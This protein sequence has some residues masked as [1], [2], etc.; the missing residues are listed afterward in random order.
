MQ[1]REASGYIQAELDSLDRIQVLPCFAFGVYEIFNRPYAQF[2]HG[3]HVDR[4]ALGRNRDTIKCHHVL[5]K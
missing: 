5:Q 1:K 4:D 3:H 2:Q